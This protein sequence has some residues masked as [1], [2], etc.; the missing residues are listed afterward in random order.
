[1]GWG[2][3]NHLNPFGAVILDA[4]TVSPVPIPSLPVTAA[5]DHRIQ[6]P[7]IHGSHLSSSTQMLRLSFA[8]CLLLLALEDHLITSTNSPVSRL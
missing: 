8:S 6:I 1:M 4:L 2:S 7:G 5:S 3:P